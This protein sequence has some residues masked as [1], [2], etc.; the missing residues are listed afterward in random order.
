MLPRNTSDVAADRVAPR[1]SPE[2]SKAPHLAPDLVAEVVSPS[3]FRPQMKDKAERYVRAGVRLVWV[4]WPQ[5]QQVDMCR[6]DA[7]GLPHLLTALEAG[8]ALDGLDVLPG[9]T[10]ALAQ[11][12]A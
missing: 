11:L 3:Q 10:Y 5:R 2:Y 4:I 9:F 7:Q 8:D 6:P 1:G 12:F